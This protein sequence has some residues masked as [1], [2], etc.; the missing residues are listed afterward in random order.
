MELSSCRKRNVVFLGKPEDVAMIAGP[1]SQ[2][3]LTCQ[4]ILD[5]EEVVRRVNFDHVG[6]VVVDETQAPGTADQVIAHI[7]QSS[8][9]PIAVIPSGDEAIDRITCFTAGAD[10]VLERPLGK[11]AAARIF[12]AWRMAFVHSNGRPTCEEDLKFGPLRFVPGQWRVTVNGQE[13]RLLPK[14]YELLLCL[15]RHANRLMTAGELLRQ[16]W[17]YPEGV[18]TRTLAVHIARIR[19]KIE[20]DPRQPS[21]IQTVPCRGYKFI[22][23]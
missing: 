2:C 10:Q 14:E 8:V 19:S 22:S 13:V 16:V 5:P 3:G 15:V 7:R 23:P 18:R 1:L 21:L 6:V 20:P 4:Q 17:G 12:A 9:V 11:A